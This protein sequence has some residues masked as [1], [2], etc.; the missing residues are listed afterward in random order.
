MAI[1]IKSLGLGG[2]IDLG[3]D[4]TEGQ[5][6]PEV[7]GELDISIQGQAVFVNGAR[8]TETEANSYVPSDG[9]DI[10]LQAKAEGGGE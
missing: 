1:S 9:D 6:L 4:G 8:L 2:K 7:M 5:S 10:E 3:L